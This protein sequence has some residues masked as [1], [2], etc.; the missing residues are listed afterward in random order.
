MAE[1]RQRKQNENEV[2][3]DDDIDAILLSKTDPGDKQNSSAAES[4]D[5]VSRIKLNPNTTPVVAWKGLEKEVIYLQSFYGYISFWT[6]VLSFISNLC[7]SLRP[8]VF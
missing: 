7:I 3:T 6:T 4:S 5:H 1:I 2:A 8:I